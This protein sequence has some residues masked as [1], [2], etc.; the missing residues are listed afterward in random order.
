MLHILQPLFQ[1]T[2][3]SQGATLFHSP[4]TVSDYFNPRSPHRERRDRL[5]PAFEYRHFNPRSPHRERR[6]SFT[7][8]FFFRHI[9]I[10][11]PLTGSDSRRYIGVIDFY[12]FNPRSP[13]RER[14]C[15]FVHAHSFIPIS[16]HA[17][18]TGSDLPNL[19]KQSGRVVKG[20]I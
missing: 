1:S 20:I 18:L 7:P 17:P 16:I 13:H 10:H 5:F 6:S 9:S 4:G 11:A 19:F 3:P 15:Y 8:P 12:N 14:Q 2:L